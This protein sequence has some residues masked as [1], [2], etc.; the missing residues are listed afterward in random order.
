MKGA[1]EGV[2]EAQDG[3]VAWRREGG[4]GGIG[5]QEGVRLE[6]EVEEGGAGGSGRWIFIARFG[7]VEV[8][9]LQDLQHVLL[10]LERWRAGDALVDGLQANAA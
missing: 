5:R 10:R 3:G 1:F 4:G 7:G 9:A 2:A 8:E 6:D